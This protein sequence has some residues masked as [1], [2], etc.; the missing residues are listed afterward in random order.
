MQRCHA[1]GGLGQL[2]C[3]RARRPLQGPVLPFPRRMAPLPGVHAQRLQHRC[4]RLIVLSKPAAP[5]TAQQQRQPAGTSRRFLSRAGSGSSTGPAANNIAPLPPGRKWRRQTSDAADKGQPSATDQ[6]L[7]RFAGAM[8]R[9]SATDFA[10]AVDP[11]AQPTSEQQLLQ[12]RS[13]LPAALKV[14]AQ[15][16]VAT[17]PAARSSGTQVQVSSCLHVT[18]YIRHPVAARQNARCNMAVSGSTANLKRANAS[19]QEH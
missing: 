12:Q 6:H 13:L 11:V 7:Q 8:R 2:S 18:S 17:K 16:L 15:K 19:S 4:S 14:S 10:S 9:G 1:M 3:L 5:Q